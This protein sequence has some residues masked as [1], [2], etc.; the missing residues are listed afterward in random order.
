VEASPSPL[1]AAPI[2][3]AP[4]SRVNLDRVRQLR[5]AYDPACELQYPLGLGDYLSLRFRLDEQQRLSEEH[6]PSDSLSARQAWYAACCT[7]LSRALELQGTALDVPTEGR[8]YDF[9]QMMRSLRDVLRARHGVFQA[10]YYEIAIGGLLR[11]RADILRMGRSVIHREGGPGTGIADEYLRARIQKVYF[12][13]FDDALLVFSCQ[14]L[15]MDDLL[16]ELIPLRVG[17]PTTLER[18]CA[19]FD[20]PN[21]ADLQWKMA[22]SL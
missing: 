16:L 3:A 2:K 14:L 15:Q 18:L 12:T 7:A 20:Y 19:E 8:A 11:Q 6:G 1:P 17:S 4:D 10:V 22:F 5:S 21:R 13:D 9:R